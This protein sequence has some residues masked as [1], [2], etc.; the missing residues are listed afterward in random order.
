MKWTWLAVV[1]LC[2]L[3]TGKSFAQDT[4]PLAK[5]DAVSSD[6]N[7]VDRQFSIAD[8]IFSGGFRVYGTSEDRYAVYNLG[9]KYSRL[10][11]WIGIADDDD[12][13]AHD[14]HYEIRVD[15]KSVLNGTTSYGDKPIRVALDV[16]GALS[17]RV[18]LAGAVYLGDPVL[19]KELPQQVKVANLLTPA[20]GTRVT[21][22]SVNLLWEP[23]DGA[24][25]YGVEIVCTKG[26]TPHI[27]ALNVSGG[28]SNIKF[29]LTDVPDGEYQWSVIAFNGSGVMGKFSKGWTFI[30]AHHAQTQ[31]AAGHPMI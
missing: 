28:D 4:V 18:T 16:T 7:T 22:N 6:L 10:E 11:G 13:D 23:L 14:R 5:I 15:G 29:D 12:Q 31:G 3:V 21:G 1:M 27:Y 19:I 8:H 2:L 30:V 9:G 17:L 26:S 24:T 25:S 20:T